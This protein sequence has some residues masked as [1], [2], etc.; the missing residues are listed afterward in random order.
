MPGS[1]SEQSSSGP[2]IALLSRQREVFMK[3]A[4]PLFGPRVSPRF[5]YAPR[6]LVL[7]LKEGKVVSREEIPLN[8]LAV[9]QRVEKLKELGVKVVICG[10]IDESSKCWLVDHQIQV[11]PLVT[12]EVGR[13]IKDFLAG[14]LRARAMDGVT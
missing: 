10:G 8:P 7:S 4:I 12:G 14:R 5:D 2:I 9:W 13:V 6:L 1:Y 11:I 3:L